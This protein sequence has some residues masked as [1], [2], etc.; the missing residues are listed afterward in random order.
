[1]TKRRLTGCPYCRL[2]KGE[3]RIEK[4]LSEN[5][6]QFEQQFKFPDCRLVFKLPFDFLVKKNNKI[7]CIEYYGE[8]HYKPIEYFGGFEKFRM[9]KIR[10]NIKQQYCNNNSIPLLILSYSEDF[11]QQ[12]ER[13]KSFLC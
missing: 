7:Q 10:D 12:K 8:Q 1:M 13:M 3:L 2:S 4:F 5:K 11:T 9:V 6:Y